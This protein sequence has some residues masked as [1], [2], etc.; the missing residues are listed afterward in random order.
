MLLMEIVLVMKLP[1]DEASSKCCGDDHP[2]LPRRAD[3]GR[4]LADPLD[5]L[6]RSDAPILLHCVRVA[7]WSASCNQLRVQR[8]GEELDHTGP[9]LDCD[10]LVDLP[11]CIR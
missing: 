10:Q 4:Q 6:G 8:Q 11:S 9:G 1:E 2:W 3:C 7:C 5:V